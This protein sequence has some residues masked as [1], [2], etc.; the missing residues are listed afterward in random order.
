MSMSLMPEFKNQLWERDAWLVVLASPPR[1][2]PPS[3]ACSTLP[4]DIT[5]R[6]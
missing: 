4:C 2:I 5:D 3:T 6:S 1:G